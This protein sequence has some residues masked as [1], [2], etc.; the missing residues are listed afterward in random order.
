MMNVSAVRQCVPVAAL[1]GLLA[2]SAAAEVYKCTD[3]NGSTRY[4]DTSCGE[5]STTIKQHAAP[6][7]AASPDERMQKTRRLLDAMEAERNQ[8][9]LAATEQQAEKERRERNCDSARDRYQ[10]FISA[11][12]LYDLDEQGNRVILTDDQRARSTEHA[13]TEVERWCD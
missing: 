11:S 10:R 7:A 13:R 4:T 6:P 5:T 9:K 12:R 8:K 3:A 1:L 2:A